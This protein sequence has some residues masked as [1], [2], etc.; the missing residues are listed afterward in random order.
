MTRPRR[1]PPRDGAATGAGAAA[2]T[3]EPVPDAEAAA[4]FDVLTEVSRWLVAKGRRQRI[5]G[6]T[7]ATYRRWQSAGGNHLVRDGP[8]IAGIFSVVREPLDDWPMIDVEGPVRWL[9][10]LATHPDFRGRGVGARAVDAA[11]R[12]LPPSELLYLDCVSDFLPAYYAAHGFE[13]VG[14]Q[15]RAYPGDGSYDITLMR[16]RGAGPG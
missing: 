13:T 12:M 6:T 7:W 14:R 15:V 11:L 10:A 16:R 9:R 1:D 2:L 4:A 5:A 8:R 3:I